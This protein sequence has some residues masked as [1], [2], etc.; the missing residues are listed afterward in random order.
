MLKDYVKNPY[1]IFMLLGDRGV[2]DRMPDE[3]FLKLIYRANTG[4]KLHLDPPVTFNEKIQWLKLHF[5]KPE[6]PA[7]ADK[8]RVRAY[9]AKKA[10]NLPM[11]P[12]LGVWDDPGE[13][14]FSALPARFVLKCTHDSGSVLICRDKECFDTDSAV[15][16]LRARLKKNYFAPGR[17]WPYKD[18]EPRVIAEE[19]VE[20]PASQVLRVYKILNFDG[21]PRIIQMI[22]NDKTKNETINYYDTDWKR[23]PFRQNFPNGTTDDPRPEGLATMLE[24][25]KLLADGFPF[26]RTDFYEVAGK[27]I[28]SEFTFFSDSGIA[29]FD[30]PEW[31]TTLGSW[32]TLPQAK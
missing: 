14:D 25:A 29:L 3:P 18:A 30:P 8:Y 9:L 22:N 1:R 13:I 20:D 26:L 2:L 19:Y 21:E 15:K 16:Y 10:P 17:E 12:L 11:I 28:F 24:N 23:L 27:V 5:R 6:F 32:I 4:K 7:M 31:D